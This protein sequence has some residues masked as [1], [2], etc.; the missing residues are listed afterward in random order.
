MRLEGSGGFVK[1]DVVAERGTECILVH[2]LRRDCETRFQ[3]MLVQTM[4]DAL[5]TC[6]RV[7]CR[8]FNNQLGMLQG[9]AHRGRFSISL[10]A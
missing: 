8:G 7:R 9:R 2:L 6:D 4:G 10:G 3:R 5:S 1:V